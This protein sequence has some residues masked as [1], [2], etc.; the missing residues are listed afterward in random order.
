M[1]GEI[2]DLIKYRISRSSE[3]YREA[4]AMIKNGF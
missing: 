3:T 1:T 2:D 4:E